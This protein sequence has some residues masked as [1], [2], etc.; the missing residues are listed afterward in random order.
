VDT[1]ACPAVLCDVM[2]VHL[3]CIFEPVPWSFSHIC[4]GNHLFRVPAFGQA[5]IMLDMLRCNTW[6]PLLHSIT[7]SFFTCSEPTDED[8]CLKYIYVFHLLLHNCLLLC[9]LDLCRNQ[10]KVTGLQK[11]CRSSVRVDAQGIVVCTATGLKSL[12]CP[13]MTVS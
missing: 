4:S 13:D 12:L 3:S 10:S 1:K 7:S 6:A 5:F 2:K 9:G 11:G 8:W